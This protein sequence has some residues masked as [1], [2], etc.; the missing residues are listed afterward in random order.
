MEAI[1]KEAKAL[2]VMGNYEMAEAYYSQIYSATCDKW[3]SFEYAQCLKK[4]NAIDRALE[5]SHALYLREP[6]F[7]YNRTLLAW[8]LYEKHYK[9]FKVDYAYEGLKELYDIALFVTELVK[10]ETHSPYEIIMLRLIKLLKKSTGHFENQRLALLD[11]LDFEMLSE[12]PRKTYR[13]GKDLTYQSDKEL[14]YSCKTKDLYAVGK[15]TACI[16]CCEEALRVIKRFHHHNDLWIK[17]RMA[18]CHAKLEGPESAI[19]ILEP[20]TRQKEH[21]VLFS[22][23]ARLYQTKGDFRTALYYFSRAALTPDLP[24]MKV[25]LYE[26]MWRLLMQMDDQ[27]HG[28]LHAQYLQ[29]IRKEEGWGSKIELDIYL[30]NPENGLV[31]NKSLKHVLSQFWHTKVTDWGK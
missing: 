14:A 10:Q 18:L 8:L 4:K 28:R 22:D 21:W 25:I 31:I 5:I 15:Y 29:Q 11:L 24:K 26:D 1:R 2:K 23:I 27:V 12:I 13:Q 9:Q 7:E 20:L 3:I 19:K 17:V 16:A 6:D 30:A